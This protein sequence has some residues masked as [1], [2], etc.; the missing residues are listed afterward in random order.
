MSAFQGDEVIAEANVTRHEN[1]ATCANDSGEGTIRIY[2][3]S[4]LCNVETY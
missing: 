2:A 3:E 4:K 1:K